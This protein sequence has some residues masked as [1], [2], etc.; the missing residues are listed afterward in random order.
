LRAAAIYA[1]RF[2]YPKEGT[3]VVYERMTRAIRER[4]GRVHLQRPV[5]RAV[6]REGRV[7]GLELP[8][9][10]VLPFDHVI[11][12]MPL[13]MLVADLPGVPPEVQ[14]AAASLT[15]RNTLL[16]YLHVDSADLFPDNWLYVHSAELRMGRITNFRNWA[17]SL[18][19]GARTTIL[20]VEYWC[21]DQDLIWHEAPD[22]LV[23]LASEEVG[24]TGLL[25]G[26][27]VL[28][29]HVVRL[30]RC[31][32]VYR[33][34]YRAQLEVVA[35]HLRTVPGLWAIGRYGAFKYNNQDHSILMGMLAA[36][37]VTGAA[38]HDLW[39]INTDYDTYQEGARITETGLEP[40]AGP[41]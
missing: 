2:A 22:R 6:M 25:R 12:T 4:G 8:G 19:G 27:A 5:K 10:E 36:E 18:H 9:G 23:A 30:P 14:R 39:S 17:P 28:D 7:A 40:G 20:V 41:P 15:F 29:G 21:F 38:A 16:V 35:R 34:G 3:G 32:P 37:N 1:E 13:T 26:A 24:R 33:R 11:S 31:Y